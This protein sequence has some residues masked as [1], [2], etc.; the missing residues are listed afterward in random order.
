MRKKPVDDKNIIFVTPGNYVAVV[1]DENYPQVYEIDAAIRYAVSGKDP[2]EFEK[3]TNKLF[4]NPYL[5]LGYI[6]CIPLILFKKKK[7]PM[8]DIFLKKF[9]EAD[10]T[11]PAGWFSAYNMKWLT[12]SVCECIFG[13]ETGSDINTNV[14]F[15]SSP[16]YFA[17]I[18]G[19]TEKIKKY[20][21]SDHYRK[22]TQLY[23]KSAL[24]FKDTE[25]LK[26][27]FEQGY[28]LAEDTIA[29][30]WR[31]AEIVRYIYTNFAE[32]I[33]SEQTD[34]DDP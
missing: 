4:S 10:R 20:L 21:D 31:D 28:E 9:R 34:T 17:M 25:F 13:I 32:Y 19:N 14:R 3:H 33:F 7:Y 2:S 27:A 18:T 26:T 30:V 29:Y 23:F 22:N 8:L 15:F 16:L 24:K 11:L 1:T 5:Q 6:V 12:S